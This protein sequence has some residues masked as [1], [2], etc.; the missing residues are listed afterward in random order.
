PCGSTRMSRH[1]E[2]TRVFLTGFSGAGKSAVAALVAEALGWRALDTDK[3]IEEAAGRAVPEIFERDGEA[4]F[5]E[6]EAEAVRKAAAQEHVVVATG[7]GAIV[8]EANRRALA[9]GLVVCLEARPESI[10]KRLRANEASYR[11]LLAGPDPLG[12]IVELKAR[13]QHLYAL[14]DAAIDTEGRTAEQVASA[15]VEAARAADPWPS[16][17]PERLLLPEERAEP[18][19]AEPVVVD[20]PSRRY[21]VHVG[22]GALDRLGEL[23]R[24][25]GLSGAA[26]VVSDTE[27]LPRH[28]E[29]ALLPLREAGFEADAFAIPAGEASKTL[30]TAATAYDWLVSKRAERGHAIVA[31]GGGVVGDLAGF[32]AAT[33]L[34]GVP[35]VQAPTSLLAMADAAIGGKVA[36]DHREAKNLIGAFYQPWLVVADVST[37]KTLPARMIVEGSAE[38]IKHALI[39]DPALLADLEAHADDLLHLEPVVTVDIVRRSA[40][41]KASVVAEDERDTGRRAILN[42]GHTVGHAIEA[43]AGYRTVLHGAADAIGM[44]AAAEIGRR[45]GITPPEVLE[46][47]RAVLERFGLPTRGPR[48]DVERVLAAMALDKKVAAGAIRWVLLEDFGRAVLR[49]DVPEDVVR[50]V[51][52]EVLS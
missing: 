32:V 38:V 49:P 13:R 21:P 7:G 29:R 36:V 37:L 6:L 34:R 9:E 35:F 10:L 8:S 11:P 48:L 18:P 51:V 14:A 28:G 20:A 12:R 5:R 44:T 15:V 39:L 31:L 45:M 46:R 52:A 42:Y 50:D 30:E 22:W 25:A 16:C 17:H 19:P 47:Q 3:L 24:D 43:A 33:Y 41:I 23:L 26:Y 1:T 4:R 27:V 2:V 40:A